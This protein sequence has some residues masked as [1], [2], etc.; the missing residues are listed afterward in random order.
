MKIQFIKPEVYSN[1]YLHYKERHVSNYLTL[2]LKEP[3]NMERQ[4]KLRDCVQ[5]K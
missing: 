5:R 3:V 1:K 2:Y 4:T